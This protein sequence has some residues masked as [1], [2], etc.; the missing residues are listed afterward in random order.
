MPNFMRR[1]KPCRCTPLSTRVSHCFSFVSNQ[2]FAGQFVFRERFVVL[3]S[4]YFKMAFAGVVFLLVVCDEGHE[5][6][7]DQMGIAKVNHD[8]FIARRKL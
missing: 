8:F 5:R 3:Q 2:F 1:F 6:V 7:V 4:S